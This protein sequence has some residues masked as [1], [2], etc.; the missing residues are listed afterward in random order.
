M[1]ISAEVQSGEKL[2][3]ASIY[4]ELQPD[5]EYERIRRFTAPAL[6]MPQYAADDTRVSN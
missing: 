1:G 6:P 3:G 5:C 4:V 2:C